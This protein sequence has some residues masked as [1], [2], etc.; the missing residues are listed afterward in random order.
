MIW[1]LGWELKQSMLFRLHWSMWRQ[2]HQTVAQ[3]HHYK[4]RQAIYSQ[5][6][7]R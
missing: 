3:F 5:D 7:S 2:Q 6:L 1:H 4:R